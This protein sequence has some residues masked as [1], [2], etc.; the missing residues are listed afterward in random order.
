MLI[1][2]LSTLEDIERIES[3]YEQ[4]FGAQPQNVSCWN[5]SKEF[6]KKIGDTLRLPPVGEAVDYSFSYSLDS[7][8]H[9]IS[10]LG[11]DTDRACLITPSGSTS[12]LCAV[13]QIK[14]S[15]NKRI[16]A[17]APHYFTL[18]H[19]AKSVGIEFKRHYIKRYERE[20]VLD[21]IVMEKGD[22]LWVT[23]PIY[24]TGMYFKE[25]DV[26]QF[27]SILDSGFKIY[28]DECLAESGIELS[29][30]LGHFDNFTGLYCP[31]KTICMNG[32]KFSCIVCSQANEQYYEQWS[33]VLYGCLGMSNTTAIDHYLS[34]NFEKYSDA[35]DA[36]ISKSWTSIISMVSSVPGLSYDMRTRG[37]L[38]LLLFPDIS[39]DVLSGDCLRKCVMDCGASFIPSTRSHCST[40]WGLGFRINLSADSPLFRS[41]LVRLLGKLSSL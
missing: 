18:E 34:D 33:D 40:E 28:A 11:F 15:G 6:K 23:N 13:K 31:H 8:S 32:M 26:D 2:E 20:Y 35:F 10:K 19:L 41:A 21:E 1:D 3:E 22:V 30:K 4:T 5:P 7:H 36:A 25:K 16:V 29:R 38:R 27:K 24:C 14:D 12:L 37:Y 17:L 9:I 39:P